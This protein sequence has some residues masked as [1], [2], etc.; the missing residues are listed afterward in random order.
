MRHHLFF[1]PILHFHAMF[2]VYILYSQLTGKFYV[3]QTN[4]LENRIER[5]NQG[6]VSSTKNGRPW[7]LIHYFECN[8]RSESMLLESKIK[9]RG[10]QRFLLDN[11]IEV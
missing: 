1:L 10:I 4:H 5:H 3:G 6:Q 8:S 7:Q 9:K 2:Y 11:N